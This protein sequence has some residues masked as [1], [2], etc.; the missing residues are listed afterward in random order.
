MSRSPL[1]LIERNSLVPF[2]IAVAGGEVRVGASDADKFAN[3]FELPVQHVICCSLEIGAFPVTVA[4]WDVYALQTGAHRPEKWPNS[5]HQRDPEH[6][7][8]LWPVR[9]VSFLDVHGYLKWLSDHT[10]AYYRL[11]SEAEWEYCC[12]AGTQ[13]VFSTGDFIELDQANYLYSEIGEH[14]GL[15]H[16]TPVGTYAPNA[17]GLYDMHGNVLELTADVWHPSLDGLPVDATARKAIS[18]TQN[19]APRSVAV[20]GGAWDYPP[21]LLRSSYRDAVGVDTRLDNVGFR[22]VREL[23]HHLSG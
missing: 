16:P 2:T 19:Q 18:Q 17:F 20:R 13:T 5:L 22:V 23:T 10:S 4:Q 8:E 15:G 6:D 9:G 14:I 1:T 12:R 3:S 11:P 7:P 21:R